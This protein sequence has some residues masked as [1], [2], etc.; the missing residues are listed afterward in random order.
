MVRWRTA[1]GGIKRA[2]THPEQGFPKVRSA[3]LQVERATD[4]SKASRI[5][6]GEPLAA[7]PWP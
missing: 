1:G 2:F 7:N 3:V 4:A 5:H 6:H